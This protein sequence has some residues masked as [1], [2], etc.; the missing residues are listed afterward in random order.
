MGDGRMRP[1]QRDR[2]SNER[3]DGGHR[4][5][6]R[7]RTGPRRAAAKHLGCPLIEQTAGQSATGRIASQVLRHRWPATSLYRRKRLPRQPPR[8]GL[9]GK[10]LAIRLPAAVATARVLGSAIHGA[11]YTV[12]GSSGRCSSCLPQPSMSYLPTT[13]PLRATA[14]YPSPRAKRYQRPSP[15]P[16]RLVCT[17]TWRQRRRPGRSPGA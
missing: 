2:P 5:R 10:R 11:S 6:R 13:G 14:R 4:T 15:R 1:T 8:T 3:T 16:G 12:T 9:P 7:G 17:T